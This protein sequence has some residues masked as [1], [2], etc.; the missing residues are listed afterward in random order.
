MQNCIVTSNGKAFVIHPL[1]D[2]GYELESKGN[3]INFQLRKPLDIIIENEARKW[4]VYRIHK[5]FAHKEICLVFI[6]VKTPAEA[7]L[8]FH[9]DIEINPPAKRLH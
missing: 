9:L 1:P 4:H 2:G 8:F 7:E 6:A 3:G 5:I